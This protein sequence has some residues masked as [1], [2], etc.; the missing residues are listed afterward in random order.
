MIRIIQ[1]ALLFAVMIPFGIAVKW[2]VSNLPAKE[3]AWFGL[4]LLSGMGIYQALWS[5]HDRI[6][7]RQSRGE[8]SFWD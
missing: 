4:G 3:A 6:K 1:I 8:Y 7:E 2:G 5:W